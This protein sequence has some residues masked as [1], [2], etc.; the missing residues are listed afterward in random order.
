MADADMY[1][2][3]KAKL[4]QLLGECEQTAATRRSADSI[5]NAGATTHSGSPDRDTADRIRASA[6]AKEKAAVER[7]GDARDVG[8][9]QVLAYPSINSNRLFACLHY[10][11]FLPCN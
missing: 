2:V 4:F 6:A 7:N 3:D 11:R 10:N 1:E 5:L 8:A 9:P